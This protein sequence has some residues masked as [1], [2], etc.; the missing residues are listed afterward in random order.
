VGREPDAAVRE[1]VRAAIAAAAPECDVAALAP[2]RPLRE[3]VDLDSLDWLNLVDGLGERLGARAGD[4]GR[5]ATLDE[6]VAWLAAAQPGGPA[7]PG[8]AAAA[9][10]DVGG[11]GLHRLA[12]GRVV[13][14]RPL[15][16][17]DAA[18]EAWFV[19]HLSAESRYQRF[20]T[21]VRELPERKLKDLTDVDGVR[22][23]ALLA[24]AR[25]DGR[26]L[27]LGV[28]HYVVDPGGTACEFAIVVGDACQGSGLAGLLM[29]ALIGTARARGLARMEGDVLSSNRDMLRFARQLGFRREPGRA[30]GGVVRVA[31]ELQQPQRR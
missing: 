2:D 31:L 17:R 15:C 11:G 24:T 18:L 27:P 1:A 3:Q 16:P 14:L 22:H 10:G 29:S 7:A 12:D 30:D 13:E 26:E 25:E 28:A 4:P 19:A 8:A 9:P 5:L 20:M 23:V 6:L 21:T